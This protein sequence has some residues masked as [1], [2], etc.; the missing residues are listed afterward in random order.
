MHQLTA[1]SSQGHPNPDRKISQITHRLVGTT[2]F[3]NGFLHHIIVAILID[4]AGVQK[5]REGPI[6]KTEIKLSVG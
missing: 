3:W 5:L 4:I 1:D 2:M 6:D